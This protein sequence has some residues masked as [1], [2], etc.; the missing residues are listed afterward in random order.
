MKSWER[1]FE[2][3]EKLT[4]ALTDITRPYVIVDVY[5]RRSVNMLYFRIRNVG[6]T[7]AFNI[8]AKI[9]PPIPFRKRSSAE[10]SIFSRAIGTIAPKEEISF[11][12]DSAVELLNREKPLLQFDV[13]L[14]YSDTHD[15]F[16][17]QTIHI[18]IEVLK[19]LSLE[20]PALDKVTGELEQIHKDLEKIARYTEHLLQEEMMKDFHESEQQNETPSAMKD[21]SEP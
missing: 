14:E 7:P 8:S 18:D 21:S 6:Y 15:V 20:L 12:F 2:A 10:L 1:C 3:I 9:D 4:E 13:L 17:R 16:Y 5:P 11:F 19:N